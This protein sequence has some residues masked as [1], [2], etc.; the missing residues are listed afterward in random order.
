MSIG[1][2][3]GPDLTGKTQC[4]NSGVLVAPESCLWPAIQRFVG[5]SPLL[6]PLLRAVG[7][8]LPLTGSSRLRYR[9]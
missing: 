9:A 4:Q 7:S 5:V 2:F 6:W 3:V 8:C 1:A